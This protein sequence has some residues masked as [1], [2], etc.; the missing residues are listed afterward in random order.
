MIEKRKIPWWLYLLLLAGMLLISYYLSGLFCYEDLSFS[1]MQGYAL[2]II[3]HPFTIWWNE[4][5]PACLCVGFLIWIFL[6]LYL[7]THYRNFHSGC[8]YGTEEWADV[9]ALDKNCL[10]YTSPLRLSRHVLG[11]ADR[12][13]GRSAAPPWPHFSLSYSCCTGPFGSASSFHSSLDRFPTY[14]FL[15]SIRPFFLISQCFPGTFI[16]EN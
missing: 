5:T 12:S 1:N 7:Q 4:K 3:R 11:G 16:S 9:R 14:N 13:A 8:E 10:L 15:P 2:Y 6:A